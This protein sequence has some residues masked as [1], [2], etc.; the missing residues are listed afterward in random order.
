MFCA[1]EVLPAVGRGSGTPGRAG[2]TPAPP[3]PDELEANERGFRTNLNSGVEA[4]EDSELGRGFGRDDIGMSLEL[5]GWVL[6]EAGN[7]QPVLAA[8]GAGDGNNG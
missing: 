5:G 6:E 4:V 1:G 7:L 3:A 2:S 8:S